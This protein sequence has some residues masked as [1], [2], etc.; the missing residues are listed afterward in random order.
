MS[1]WPHLGRMTKGI[2][3]VLAFLLMGFFVGANLWVEWETDGRLTR[4]PA[5]VPAGSVAVVLGCNE[6]DVE[7]GWRV[8]SY[9]PRLDAAARL[10]ASGRVRLVIVSGYLS[11]ADAMAR[12]LRRRG[13]AV[14]V[15]LDPYGWRTL[16][17][18]ARARA[19][20]P[21]APLVFVSQG[22][23]AD[24]AVW[25]A[26]RLGAEASGFVAADGPGLRARLLGRARDLF[27]KPKAVIDWALGFPL[28][29]DIPPAEGFR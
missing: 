13:V 25:Q 2:L 7:D 5:A 10:A 24:R 19:A 27:A 9:H 15:V 4:D 3:G 6:F 21:G 12:E 29:T 28:T 16:D 20:H 8:A 11:Q 18:V 26:R 22:W 14:P 1:K 23:H 17:S